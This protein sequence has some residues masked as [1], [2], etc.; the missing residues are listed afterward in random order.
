M[1]IFTTVL[2][3]A[4][5]TTL[6]NTTNTETGNVDESEADAI[7]DNLEESGA[8]EKVE[9]SDES[10]TY[11]IT[12][13]EIAKSFRANGYEK[14]ADMLEE[15]S[16]STGPTLLSS[17]VNSFTSNG[18]GSYTIKLNE[19]VTKLVAA[20]GS[21][22]ATTLI[23]LIPGLGWTVAAGAAGP[24]AGVLTSETINDGVSFTTANVGGAWMI[25]DWH[26]Q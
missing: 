16:N 21:G 3:V 1:V 20:G 13:E 10:T 26:W 24:M 25:L 14:E 17:G 6:A 19:T 15:Q 12:N 11:E 7:K 18:D 8:W 5:P 9:D 4:S 23:G 2:L 22:V